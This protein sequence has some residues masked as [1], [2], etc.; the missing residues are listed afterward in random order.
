MTTCSRSQ[1]LSQIVQAIVDPADQALAV[2]SHQ[3]AN[4]S[5]SASE[6]LGCFACFTGKALAAAAGGV[7]YASQQQNRACLLGV[8]HAI[9]LCCHT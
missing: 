7:R 1:L 3:A 2:S 4:M 5:F 6:G 9:W 8:L